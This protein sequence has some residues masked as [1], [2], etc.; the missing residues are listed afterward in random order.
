[1]AVRGGLRRG[2]LVAVQGDI[3]ATAVRGLTP[4]QVMRRPWL[5]TLEQ[6]AGAAVVLL[7][8]CVVV[9]L[10]TGLVLVAVVG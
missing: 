3:L 8:L 10:N 4:A 2:V 6:A 5:E 7:G 1:M 9:F